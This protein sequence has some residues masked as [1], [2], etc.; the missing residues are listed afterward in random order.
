[1]ADLALV[2]L[3]VAFG[4]ARTDQEP[5]IRAVLANPNFGFPNLGTTLRKLVLVLEVGSLKKEDEVLLRSQRGR[6]IGIH[7]VKVSLEHRCRERVFEAFQ[8][9]ARVGSGDVIT[10]FLRSINSSA[11]PPIRALREASLPMPSSS[12]TVGSSLRS[13][14]FISLMRLLRAVLF[15]SLFAIDQEP[16]RKHAWS[17]YRLVQTL[18]ASDGKKRPVIRRL[19]ARKTLH[20]QRISAL[21][22]PS[23]IEPLTS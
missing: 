11:L 14:S 6:E 7:V 20:L 12:S 3:P 9:E 5:V 13:S 4:E 10:S 8:V 23:G 2:I 16:L 15:G 17:R 19:R 18:G 21:V 1:M 22:E